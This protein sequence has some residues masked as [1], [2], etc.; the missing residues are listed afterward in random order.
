MPTNSLR[1]QP[2]PPGKYVLKHVLTPK[3]GTIH[4]SSISNVVT[5]SPYRHGSEEVED[6]VVEG[7]NNGL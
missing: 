5:Q 3:D 2:I 1:L 7:I 6:T 4:E